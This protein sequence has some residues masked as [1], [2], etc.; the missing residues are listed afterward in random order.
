MEKKIEVQS[1]TNL[2][3][4]DKILKKSNLK[5]LWI[6]SWDQSNHVESKFF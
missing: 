3:L 2:I 1:P 4:N 6:E 5:N